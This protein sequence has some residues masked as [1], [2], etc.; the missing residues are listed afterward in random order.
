MLEILF[1]MRG[2][3]FNPRV[4]MQIHDIVKTL[5]SEVV[6][7]SISIW[8]TRLNKNFVTR[9]IIIYYLKLYQRQC[10]SVCFHTCMNEF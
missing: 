7:S 2:N 4:L 3:F 1:H 8:I 6:S 5:T 10:F 9:N